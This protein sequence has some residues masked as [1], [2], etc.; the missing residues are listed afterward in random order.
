MMTNCTMLIGRL[1][2]EPKVLETENGNK[3]ANMTI[4]VTR[5]F[6]NA[7]GEYDTDFVDCL[8]WR[9]VAENVSLYCKKGDLIGVKGR[10]ESKPFEKDGEVKKNTRIVADKV[11]FLSKARS[12]Q[13]EK[14]QTNESTTEKTKEKNNDK[15]TKKESSKERN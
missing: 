3:Y 5:T 2:E 15:K 10:I 12:N 6:K 11:S 8:L 4:A 7:E 13:E 9:G 1:V 14:E